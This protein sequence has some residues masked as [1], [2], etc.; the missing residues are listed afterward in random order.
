MTAEGQPIRLKN[1]LKIAV[2]VGLAICGLIAYFGFD[3]QKIEKWFKST[4]GAG[5]TPTPSLTSPAGNIFLAE[6]PM[7]TSMLPAP[8]VKKTPMAKKPKRC[9]TVD[10]KVF[11]RKNAFRIWLHLGKPEELIFENVAGPDA[12]D[13]KV[14]VSRGNLPGLVNNGDR[15]CL[16]KG[17]KV[18]PKF[19]RSVPVPQSF[20]GFITRR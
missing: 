13:K 4:E 3:Q 1:I 18:N 17:V 7:P 11:K 15:F 8:E 6:T 5:A 9:A 10:S 20:P 2:P 12:T 19:R 14:R 16:L